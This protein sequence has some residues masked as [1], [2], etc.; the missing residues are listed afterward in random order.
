MSTFSSCISFRYLRATISVTGSFRQPSSTSGTNNGH[1][2]P[3][4]VISGS[5]CWISSLYRWLLMVASVAITPT[6]FF[7]VSLA[8]TLAPGFTTPMIGISI[9]FSRVSSASALAVLQ[10]ITIAFTPCFCRNRTICLEYRITVS[11]DLLP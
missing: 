2:F 8:A 5:I 10:A 6:L 4:T 1:G 7:V 11:L 9:S 3:T